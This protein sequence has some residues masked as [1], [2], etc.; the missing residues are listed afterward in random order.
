MGWAEG[1]ADDIPHGI[2]TSVFYERDRAWCRKTFISYT[3]TCTIYGN[4]AERVRSDEVLVSIVATN[5]ARK[6]FALGIEAAAKLA[7]TQNVRLWIK[8][9]VQERHWSIPA[10]L[11][12]FGL[13]DRSMITLS[14]LTDDAMARAYSASDI[15]L[16]IAPEG[17]GYIHV[18]SLSCG[19]PC[20]TGSYAGGAELVSPLMRIDPVAFRYESIW[21]CKR[22]VYDP[23][24]WAKKAANWLGQRVTMD[25]KYDWKEL[26]P[27]WESWFR[28]GLK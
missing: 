5:Q 26:W 8:T 23:A 10:L 12:D 13:A 24:E 6:D 3:N 21:S 19:T 25:R 15:V 27:H 9:D 11:L 28:E 16:G 22:P 14:E 4:L 18:E 17:F 1:T 20:I 7:Q 2:D